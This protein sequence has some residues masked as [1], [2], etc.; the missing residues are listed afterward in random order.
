MF[1]IYK[2]RKAIIKAVGEVAFR[3]SLRVMS[4]HFQIRMTG[5]PAM[6]RKREHVPLYDVKYSNTMVPM[7]DG[8]KLNTLHLAPVPRTAGKDSQNKGTYTS[9][10]IFIGPVVLMRTPYSQ[11]LGKLF[12]HMFAQRGE[13]NIKLHFLQT[14]E[15]W[16]HKRKSHGTIA[17]SN[18]VI[19]QCDTNTGLN[20]RATPL[21]HRV[22]CCAARLQGPVWV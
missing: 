3:T 8:I 20:W 18:R 1:G 16:E 19:L 10:E 5:E 15:N 12:A 17:K 13:Q 22:S 21:H 11:F 9:A 6:Q 7:P 2:R 14:N 4:H